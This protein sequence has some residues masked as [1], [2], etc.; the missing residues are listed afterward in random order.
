M[1]FLAFND[2]MFSWGAA[3]WRKYQILRPNEALMW[4][5]IKFGKARGLK[6]FDMG[7][8]GDYKRKYGGQEISIPL[9]MQGKYRF[10]IPLRNAA[11]RAWR[12]RQQIRGKLLSL[13]PPE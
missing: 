13:T 1:I 7:G 2:T 9:F 5:A 4:Y 8:G 10:L 11:Q 3:S 12:W 6:K